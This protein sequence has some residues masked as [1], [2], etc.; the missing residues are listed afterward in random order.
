MKRTGVLLGGEKK[1]IVPL[2]EFV[3]KKSTGGAFAETFQ[4]IEP[5]KKK[6]ITGDNVLFYN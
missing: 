5:K 1:V 2:R 3:L 6:N 4:G